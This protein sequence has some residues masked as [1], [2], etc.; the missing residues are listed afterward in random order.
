[1]IQFTFQATI[2][3]AGSDKTVI[4]TSTQHKPMFKT[5]NDSSTVGYA[6]HSTTTT[7]N[8]PTN[9]TMKGFTLETTVDNT[10]MILDSTKN[11]I[12]E[13]VKVK[14]AWRQ[15]MQLITDIGLQLNNLSTSVETK[16][17]HL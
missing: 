13:D 9:I 10:C 15:A 12:F 14:G 11:S 6:V 2:I 3:G 8:P 7:I 1:M 16:I 4:R 17:I 5:V